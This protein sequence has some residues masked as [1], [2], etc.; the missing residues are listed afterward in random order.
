MESRC[1][2]FGDEFTE[3][4]KR[5]MGFSRPRCFSRKISTSKV[6]T[7]CLLPYLISPFVCVLDFSIFIWLSLSF[8]IVVDVHC[9]F[10]RLRI[11]VLKGF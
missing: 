2:G 6:F 7:L 5:E 9:K 1:K 11:H 10:D 4:F 8:R 3:L